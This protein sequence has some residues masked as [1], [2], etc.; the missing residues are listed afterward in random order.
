MKKVVLKTALKTVLGL[1]IAI[2]IAFCVASFG[3][4]RS[5]AAMCEKTGN[6]SLAATY[7]S[8]S[9]KYTADIDDLARCAE[10]SIF[11]K[12]DSKIIKYCE[13]LLSHEKFDGLCEK[14]SGKL[15]LGNMQVELNYKQFILDNLSAA[16]ER[17]GIN[18]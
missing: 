18:N 7:S 10:D 5:M 13:R 12:N 8:L 1:L 4:P 9:Y 11:A 14:K 16:K 3:F 2:I 15:T 6:Y 17:K